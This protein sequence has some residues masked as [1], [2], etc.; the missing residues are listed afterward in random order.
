MMSTVGLH[1]RVLRRVAGVGGIALLAAAC[2][3]CSSSA[4]TANSATTSP[5]P[6]RSDASASGTGV[7]PAGSA[8]APLQT[9]A[10]PVWARGGFSGN[11]YPPFATSS[12]GDLVGLV[13]GDPLSAP[14]APTHNNK[15]LWVERNGARTMEVTA[16]LEGSDEVSHQ[17]LD[18][19]PSI[20]DMP[21]AGCWHLDL[22]IGDRRD[23]LDLRWNEG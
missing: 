22:R 21:A 9:G 16:R 17:Q 13:F 2:A 14:P 10:P 11:S 19:G 7:A 3:G 4:P 6:A 12:S 20:V 18:V 8:C 15:I 23:S 1:I 5:P